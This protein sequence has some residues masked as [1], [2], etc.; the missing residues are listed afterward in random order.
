MIDQQHEDLPG[1]AKGFLETTPLNDS[2][3]LPNI[4]SGTTARAPKTNLGQN[5]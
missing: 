1:M 2:G 4:A 5:Q 3:V